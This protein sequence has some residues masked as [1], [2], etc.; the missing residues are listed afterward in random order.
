MNMVLSFLSD[1]CGDFSCGIFDLSVKIHWSLDWSEKLMIDPFPRDSSLSRQSD[2]TCFSTKVLSSNHLFF[3]EK[4][5]WPIYLI[6][7]VHK[8]HPRVGWKWQN[9]FKP[10]FEVPKAAKSIHKLNLSPKQTRFLVPNLTEVDKFHLH[11]RQVNT[12]S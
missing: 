3:Q 12:K 1:A 11:K 2:M 4:V 9:K 7:I 5:F 8:Y 6:H 10:L